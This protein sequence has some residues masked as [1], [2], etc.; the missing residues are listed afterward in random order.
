MP[1][2]NIPYSG[3]EITDTILK[4]WITNHIPDY[5][6]RI[7]QRSD[8][9]EF[10]SEGDISKV[11][12]FSAKQK[13]PPI[14]K[15]LASNFYNRLRFAFINVESEIGAPLGEEFEIEKWPT[16]LVHT[17]EGDKVIYD[18][19]MKLPALKEF[20]APHA[21]AEG[22]EKEERVIGSKTQTTLNNQ[23]DKSGYM[24]LTN[25]ADI[26]D[27]IL[28]DQRAALIFVATKDNMLHSSALEDIAQ[29]YGDFINVGMYVVDDIQAS[30]SEL[31]KEFKSTK[32]P[33]FRY[34]P[35]L[36]KDD[37]KKSASHNIVLPSEAYDSEFE[38]A[39]KEAIKSA[40]V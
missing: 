14:Y 2:E 9:D 23:K 38:E 34:Y 29:E 27:K 19:K 30:S 13:V 7:S 21:L 37:A 18:G 39:M 6:A 4:N 11:Y 32:L 26:E 40:I 20:V 12:L 28:S 16:L 25:P 8:A 24:L 3:S 17:T 31:K 35:N 5:T 36:K 22:E 10:A 1:N 33:I 15:A